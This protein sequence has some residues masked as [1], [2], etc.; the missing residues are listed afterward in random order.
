MDKPNWVDLFSNHSSKF[1]IWA[2]KIEVSPVNEENEGTWMW[3]Q[4]QM[5][6][7]PKNEHLTLNELR[8]FI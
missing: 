2:K 6:L 3:K 4:G 5:P 1:H 7:V 8:I